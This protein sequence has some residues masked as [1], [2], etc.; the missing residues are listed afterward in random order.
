MIYR[1][2]DVW[3]HDG[4]WGSSFTVTF[5][6][7]SGT[8]GSPDGPSSAR[9]WNPNWVWT[10]LNGDKRTFAG[11]C[12]SPSFLFSVNGSMMCPEETFSSVASDPCRRW[13]FEAGGQLSGSACRSL[14]RSPSFGT[15]ASLEHCREQARALVHCR[16]FLRLSYLC[17][18]PRSVGIIRC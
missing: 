5:D 12:F 1:W 8:I 7:E 6:S 2:Q 9:P 18:T 11:V 4:L 16:S 3:I 15:D 17:L 13:G 14:I 10:H